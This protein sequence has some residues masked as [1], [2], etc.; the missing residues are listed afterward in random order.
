MKSKSVLICLVGLP[1]AGKSTLCSALTSRPTSSYN[2]DYIC[3]DQHINTI[4]HLEDPRGWTKARHLLNQTITNLVQQRQ[5]SVTSN[6]LLV[7][8]NFYYRGMRKE[9]YHIAQRHAC[10]FGQV[11][12]PISCEL[13]ISNNYLRTESSVA[14]ATIQ[15][16]SNCI[17]LPSEA[18]EKHVLVLSKIEKFDDFTLENR[19]EKFIGFIEWLMQQSVEVDP[20]DVVKMKENER[21]KNSEDVIQ[22][23]G[24][25]IRKR[26]SQRMKEDKLLHR[27]VPYKV[28]GN[29]KTLLLDKLKE[30]KRV[31]DNSLE[32]LESIVVDQFDEM[33]CKLSDR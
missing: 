26:I 31:Q 32:E 18:W 13:S 2:I 7:D 27:N 22:Q 10:V 14:S 1:A 9:V 23:C 5:S 19:L 4:N 24:I 3:Y 8:D 12:F 16:M 25:I 17:E 11:V 28:Y 33:I 29:A 30:N 21:K 6:I 20:Q 15:K